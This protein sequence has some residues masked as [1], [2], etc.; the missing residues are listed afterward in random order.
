MTLDDMIAE[1]K[2]LGATDIEVKVATK[3]AKR[4]REALEASLSAGHAPGGLAWAPRK[5]DGGRAY[6]NAASRLSVKAIGDI[7]RAE[8]TGPEV[9]GHFGARGMPVRQ[10]LP[11][12]SAGMPPEV[13][14][15]LERAADDVFTEL[16]K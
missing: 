10:M 13:E 5:E 7:I 15:A 9:Y 1:L 11:D 4:L 14:R 8:V 6:A 12:G 2:S 16:T 3:G